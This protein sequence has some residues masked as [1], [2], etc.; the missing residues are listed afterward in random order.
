M[1]VSAKLR[2][3]P[4]R[5]ATGAY[6]LNTGVTKLNADDDTAKSLHGMASNTYPI[7]SKVDPKVFIRALAV[8]EMAVGGALLL[9]I[10][11]PVVAGAALAGFSGVLL[12][13]YWRTPGMHHEGSVRPTPQGTAVSKDVW[14]MGIGVGLMAD[15]ALEG[16]HDRVVEI[17]SSMSR[18]RAAAGKRARRKARRARRADTDQ[19]KNLLHRADELSD[20][21]TK[22]L[23][24]V[25]AEYAPIAAEKARTAGEVARHAAEEYGPVAAEKARSAREA[26]RQAAQD[27][28]P[29]AAEKA[30]SAREAARQAY[31]EYRPV[32]A[33]KARS[34]RE[35]ARQ[36]YEDYGP[37]VT[38]TAKAARD[39]A[40]EYGNKARKR[41]AA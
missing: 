35:A 16:T 33:K 14:M 34:A 28:G 11:P 24:E 4:L 22:R 13:T 39:L 18:R 32:A 26:A 7:F 1:S 9:P 23:A 25:R 21:A 6:I 17:E 20:A 29:V 8:G 3:A 12:N 38:E 19:L 5:I 10:V 36:A 37:L 15:A 41:F 2:R 40:A 31:Q 30:R 27:Y